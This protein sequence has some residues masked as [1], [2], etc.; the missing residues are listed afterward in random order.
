MASHNPPSDPASM[1]NCNHCTATF[2][3]KAVLSVHIRDA[4][5]DIKPA[6]NK[7]SN[8]NHQSL[9][10]TPNKTSPVAAASSASVQV[11]SPPTTPANMNKCTICGK[12]FL[13]QDNLKAHLL[14]HRGHKSFKCSVC[15]SR[16]AQKTNLRKHMML[17]HSGHQCP[18][19]TVM[20]RS[21]Q[22]LNQHI[23][24]LHPELI[25]NIDHISPLGMR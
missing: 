19:C 13:T 11:R 14:Y 4:H 12:Q 21:E 15:G 24:S 20:F 7:K 3:T 2:T 22:D 9:V 16:F 5:P 8:G 17:S 18:H 25:G 23:T 10:K 1:F 6:P